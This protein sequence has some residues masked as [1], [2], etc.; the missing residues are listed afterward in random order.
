MTLDITLLIIICERSHN[1]ENGR[2]GMA[3]IIYMADIWRKCGGYMANIRPM[4]G[5]YAADIRRTCACETCGHTAR[6]GGGGGLCPL[7]HTAEIPNR[8]FYQFFI[9]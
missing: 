5:R 3:D 8:Q 2:L 6:G 9:M 7:R 1:W 4:V